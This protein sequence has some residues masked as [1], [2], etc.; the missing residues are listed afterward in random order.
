MKNKGL[1]IAGLVVFFIIA[2]TPWWW[3]LVT[4]TKAKAPEPKLTAKAEA[5][6]NCVESKDFMKKEHMQ[7]LDQWR[8]EVVRQERRTYVNTEGKS[9]DMSLTNT[10]LDCHSNKAEFCDSCHNYTSVRP[11]CFD[12]HNIP[13]EAN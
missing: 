11:Y 4:G 12:C 2:L 1:I 6:K 10:C 13:K 3:N 8:E 7:L 9:F 5:A